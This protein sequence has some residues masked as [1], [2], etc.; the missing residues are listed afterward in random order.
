[1]KKFRFGLDNVLDYRWQVLDERQ[2]EYAKALDQVHRQEA[3][4]ADAETRYR[5]LNHQFH[6][7]AARGITA[8]DALTYEGGLRLLEQ[9]IARETRILEDL[10]KAAEDKRLL[11]MQAHIDTTALERLREK[12]MQEYKKDLQKSEERFIDDL[13][14]A[15]RYGRTG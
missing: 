8:V 10:R 7:E 4:K 2:G 14:S 3:R 13:V 6:E 1:M 11:M 12:K 5:D 15:A 9:E